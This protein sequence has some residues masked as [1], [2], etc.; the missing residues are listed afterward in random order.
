M[1]YVLRVTASQFLVV[2]FEEHV[3]FSWKI[4][5]SGVP[6]S[7]SRVGKISLF[8][9]PTLGAFWCVCSTGFHLLSLCFEIFGVSFEDQDELGL[10]PC[11]MDKYL[12]E[13]IQ[14]YL[15]RD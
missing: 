5:S 2:F 4:V 11:L 7:G 10:S 3:P 1:H 13:H 8:V 15:V 6:C 9:T 14:V 12:C